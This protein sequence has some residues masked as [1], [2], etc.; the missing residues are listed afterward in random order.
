MN[1]FRKLNVKP[2]LPF[3][4]SAALLIASCAAR[5]ASPP[6]LADSDQG[7]QPSPA[8]VDRGW[9]E[10]ATFTRML[11]NNPETPRAGDR[12]EPRFRLHPI[13]LP[14]TEIGRNSTTT[15]AL[16]LDSVPAIA[17]LQ[18]SLWHQGTDRRPAIRVN[19]VAA[20]TLE[21]TF[22]SLSER[23]YVF[24]LFPNSD[25]S[26]DTQLDYQGWLPARCFFGG[27]LLKPG[28]NEIAMSVETDQ[29]KI[30]D[31]AV[32]ALYAPDAADTVHDFTKARNK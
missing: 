10:P 27:R 9:S 29:I 14:P 15:F 3:V 6:V 2:W 25:G 22:P 12:G 16:E 21:P 30:R 28:K 13:A 18:M 17:C 31:V 4:A 26:T 7:T 32:E 23:N 19:G 8:V 20:G 5:T 11:A 24:F 1:I